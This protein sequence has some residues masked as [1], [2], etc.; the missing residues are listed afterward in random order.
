MTD[1]DRAPDPRA[2]EGMP[3]NREERRRA[4][5]RP[6]AGARDP[7]AAM[8]PRDEAAGLGGD[9]DGSFAGGRGG[10]VVHDTGTGTAG[11]TESDGRARNHEAIH[12]GNQPNS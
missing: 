4:R 3:M 9:D 7:H 8:P 5:F 12:L 6:R 11:A 2:P 10:D 1:H